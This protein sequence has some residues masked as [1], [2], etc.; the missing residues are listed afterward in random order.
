MMTSYFLLMK[1]QM[2][3]LKF[4]TKKI[5]NTLIISVLFVILLCYVFCKVFRKDIILNDFFETQSTGFIYNNNEIYQQENFFSN[6]ISFKYFF[7]ENRRFYAII[8]LHNNDIKENPIKVKKFPTSQYY[9]EYKHRKEDY[10][11]ELNVI[12]IFDFNIKTN[13]TLKYPIA[14]MNKILVKKYVDA[15]ENDTLYYFVSQ[16]PLESEN[17]PSKEAFLVS[18]KRG[19][20]SHFL[21]KSTGNKIEISFL[22][23]IYEPF[24]Y[25]DKIVKILN[26]I[27]K[28]AF[29]SSEE[30][31]IKDVPIF[32]K[33][34]FFQ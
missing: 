1:K 4:S 13:D 34:S 5:F 9:E 30:V 11:I 31:N 32:D 16:F 22:S 12:K 15:T 18:Q 20:I 10:D 6:T 26:K 14:Q 25:K 8:F 21:V 7:F 28:G 23:G 33:K 29:K 17:Y 24:L 27:K 3:Y 19:I 2:T